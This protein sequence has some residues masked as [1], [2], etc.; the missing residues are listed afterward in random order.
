[1][2]D[3]FTECRT[4]IR[5]F[6]GRS[7]PKILVSYR[8]VSRSKGARF[9]AAPWKTAAGLSA[10]GGAGLTIASLAFY[11][12]AAITDGFRGSVAESKTGPA[13]APMAQLAGTVR[14]SQDATQQMQRALE[15]E[16]NE[17]QDSERTV[18]AE[19]AKRRERED[20][21][22]RARRDSAPQRV[23]SETHRA[24]PVS[25]TIQHDSFTGTHGRVRVTWQQEG[26]VYNAVVV[27]N[28]T[29]GSAIV[30]Y[31]DP[32]T[33]IPVGAE[34]DLELLQNAGGLFYVGANPR[35]P[36]TAVPHPF[37]MRDIFKLS[38]LPNGSW[39]I[40]EVGENWEHFDRVSTIAQ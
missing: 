12:G 23:E 2:A 22:E 32:L 7:R 11:S 17:R 16:R 6:G 33:A 36:G 25:Q 30:N 4:R 35:V 10:I 20:E 40:S 29:R 38:S 5:S 13:S 18:G 15:R 9:K 8:P 1:M 28:G 37:Y 3:I 14:S 31:I 21:L 27:T 24:Q 34:Q 19:R 26:V 39:T